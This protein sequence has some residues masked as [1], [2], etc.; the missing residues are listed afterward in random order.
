[1]ERHHAVQTTELIAFGQRRT[2]PPFPSQVR[3]PPNLE[4]FVW[5]PVWTRQ[6]TK[7][8]TD[9]YDSEP[10]P[11]YRKVVQRFAEGVLQLFDSLQEVMVLW[12]EQGYLHYCRTPRLMEGWAYPESADINAWAAVPE[13]SS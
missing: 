5:A 12:N 1:M 2:D 8:H 10:G 6:Y 7:Q 4:T 3:L 13:D 9:L 11:L